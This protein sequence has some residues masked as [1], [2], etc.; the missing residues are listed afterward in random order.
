MIRMLKGDADNFLKLASAL[1]IILRRSIYDADMPQAKALPED[2]LKTFF[3]VIQGQMSYIF[4]HCNQQLHAKILKPNFHWVVHIFDQIR[5]YGPVYN[6]WTF[7]FECL[8]KVL[9][10]YLC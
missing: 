4:T 5:D 9:K 10:S 7:L 3:E 6:F 8:N 2:Y 1:K